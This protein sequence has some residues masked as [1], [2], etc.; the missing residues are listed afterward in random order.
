MP[1]RNNRSRTGVLSCGVLLLAAAGLQAPPLLAQVPPT[2]LPARELRQLQ[3][4]VERG[5]LRQELRDFERREALQPMP[6][7]Q[8]AQSPAA[9]FRLPLKSIGHTPSLVLSD[10]EFN[11][12]V[13]PW[14]GRTIQ[15]EE[16]A[17]ILNAVNEAYRARG[18]VVCQAVVKPQRIRN[19]HLEITLIEGRTDKATVSG[20]RSTNADFVL[21]AF[22]FEKGTVANYREMIDAL[23]R[24]NMTHDVAL[25]IDIS[26]GE[27][28]MST[29][30]RIDVEEPRRWTAS[31]FADTIGSEATGR[32]RV[33]ASITNRSVLGLRDSLTLLGIASE[34]SKSAM[35][36]YSLPLNA[37]GTKLSSSISFGD[38]EVVDGPSADYDVSGDSFLANLRLEHPF[39]VSQSA[40]W[41]LWGEWGRQGS[42]SSMFGDVKVS[43][44]AIDLYTAGIDGLVFSQRA[45]AA[46]TVAVSRHRVDERVFDLTSSYT[47]LVGNLSARQGFANG[48]ALTLNARWQS[49]LGGDELN[50]ADYF[51]LGHAS[52]VRGYDNDLLSAEEGFTASIEAGYPILGEG[53]WLFGFLDYGRLF[54]R[55]AS[56][57]NSLAS[58]GCGLQWPLFD[59]ASL[60]FTASFPLKR[61]L[62]DDI[63][64]N[65]ARADLLMI[66]TW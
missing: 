12:A 64:V 3:D 36:A 55:R 24:F 33:G 27:A 28:P 57:E 18:Y 47:L 46:G 37:F 63:H 17:D 56:L 59:G 35:L 22:D 32:P 61:D 60:E 66:I 19:G 25:K 26:A 8:D 15:A 53:T 11:R 44:T 43:D 54:G 21:S 31:V 23:V 65:A 6:Q 5:R 20:N 34:G 45:F 38:V 9:G 16:I 50:S 58:A 62:A 30:Y 29:A 13:A 52:G 40:R 10:D 2:D 42:N 49:V 51:Y 48:F 14:I 39:Y 7:K 41:T 4:S 1:K